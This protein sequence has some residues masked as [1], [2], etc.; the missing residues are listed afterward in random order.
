MTYISWHY[1]EMLPNLLGIARNL[2]LFPLYMFSVPL[3][4]STLFSPWKKQYVEKRPGFHLDDILSVISF[5]VIS[6]AI[7]A[8]MR[9]VLI[10][11]GLIFSLFLGAAGIL[12]PLLWIVLPFVTFPFYLARRKTD[13]EEAQN[14]YEK[15]KNNMTFLCIALLQRKEASFITRHLNLNHTQLLKKLHEDSSHIA[16]PLLPQPISSLPDLW[17]FTFQNHPLLSESLNNQ[18]LTIE[19]VKETANWYGKKES[20]TPDPLITNLSA[21]KG[22]KGFGCDWAYG[23]TPTLD[24]YSTDMTRIPATFPLLIG[25]ENEMRIMEQTLLK[26]TG[27]NIL[28]VGE[29][30]TARHLTVET[31]AFRIL[32]GQCNPQI[33]HKR[34]IQL[35]MT[36]ILSGHS[37]PMDAKDFFRNIIKEAEFAGNIIIVIDDFE[38]Y[39]GN[40]KDAVDLSDILYEV[41]QSRI[42]VIGITTFPS[43]HSIIETHKEFVTSFEKIEIHPPSPEVL[44]SELELS[45]VPVLE[46][47]YHCIVTFPSIKQTIELADRYITTHEFPDKAIELLEDAILLSTSEKQYV[48]TPSSIQKIIGQKYHIAMGSVN[49]NEKEKLLHLEEILHKRIVNQELAISSLANSLRRARLDI[50]ASNKP[51]GSFLFL[52][53]TGV[54]KTETAKALSSVYFGDESKLLRFDMSEYQKDEGLGRLIGSS[55]SNTPGEL[56]SQLLEHPSSVLLLDELEKASPDI[57]NLFLTL[58]DEGYITDHTGKKINA[59]N[60]I[61]IATSNAGAEFIRQS[62]GSG[63]PKDQI[64]TSVLEYIQTSQIF[65]PEF[66]NRFDRVIVFT[67]LSEGHLREITR[68]LLEDLNK[69]LVTKNI[70]VAITPRLITTLANLGYH[71]ER[72]A[73]EIKRVITQIVEDTVAKRLLSPEFKK[74]EILQIEV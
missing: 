6:R 69:R 38:K 55:V 43:Y 37:S 18:S 48:I 46:N 67:P 25:R 52:G 23:Y 41:S 19:D 65:T 72:G 58:V 40:E 56:T 64:E 74:G 22:L 2:F 16:A 9:G 50:S 28:I 7:G 14:L 10:F 3:H 54:G 21:I 5:N 42:G 63:I 44:I 45:I 32:S 59:K 73:R 71:P 34:V 20:I 61:I 66:L 62:L 57:L 68:M 1:F 36:Q 29:A 39:L 51:I 11:S 70:S 26:T 33:S 13:K 27:N 24:K 8:V 53:P 49:D 17:S 4:I 60:C 47:K 35:N 31:F 12:I 15:Y 30:G